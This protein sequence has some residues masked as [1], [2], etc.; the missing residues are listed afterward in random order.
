MG[1][2]ALA[3][4]QRAANARR[5]PN[6]AFPNDR[7]SYSSPASEDVSRSAEGCKQRPPDGI[8]K[9]DE[10]T[11]KGEFVR[12]RPDDK[13]WWRSTAQD[14]D[15]ESFNCDNT[16]G[17]VSPMTPSGTSNASVQQG[18]GASALGQQLLLRAGGLNQH[19]KQRRRSTHCARQTWR[20]VRAKRRA[21]HPCGRLLAIVT[22][23]IIEPCRNNLASTLP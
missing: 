6:V 14:D 3:P 16:W 9:L 12:D 4:S 19:A 22:S 23:A 21:R 15:I 8:T 11:R 13:R 5:S 18:G 20:S 17:R 7:L 2:I 10:V 1:S